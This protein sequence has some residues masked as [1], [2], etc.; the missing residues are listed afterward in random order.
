MK[1][2]VLISLSL[3]TM[4]SSSWT[5]AKVGKA[6][7]PSEKV[8]VDQAVREAADPAVRAKTQQDATVVGAVNAD[9]K[10]DTQVLEL[11]E[12]CSGNCGLVEAIEGAVRNP[13]SLELGP[14]AQANARL[15]V[16][17][18]SELTKS[19]MDS[20]SALTKAVQD[21]NLNP[22]EIKENCKQ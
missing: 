11:S 4:A 2:H 12:T 13:D 16:A 6:V 7:V 22:E 21:M 9:A 1:K 19:G 5:Y 14:E 8:V 18:A 15:A 3:L 20:E 17:L 10:V